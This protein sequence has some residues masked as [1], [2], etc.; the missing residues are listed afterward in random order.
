MAQFDIDEHAPLLDGGVPTRGIMENDTPLDLKDE[1]Q[2][3]SSKIR[4]K[5]GLVVICILMTELCE[6]LTYYSVVANLVL[7]CT[8]H[9]DLPSGDAATVS[10]VF[11]GTVYIIPVFGGYVSDSLAGKYNTIL[12]SAL[13]YLLGLFLL[14]AAAV[15]YT[16]WFGKDDE[17]TGYD[18]S[19][20]A[21]KAYFFLGLIFVAI[22]T[23]GI[24]ANV[25]PYG[26]QQVQA[27]GP[28]AVQ[29]FF[30][31]FYWFINAGSLV[32]YSG[33]AYIQQNISFGIGFLVPLISMIVSVIIFVSAKGMY[34]NTPIGG[35]ILTDSIGVCRATRCKGFKRA[36]KQ[37]GGAYSE[38]MVDGV[39][40]V[41]RVLP[42]FLLIIMYWAVYS[43]M[44]STFFLQSERMDVMV[45]D[46][47]MPAA[48][49]N[50]FNTVIILVLIPIIDRGIY[51]LL[52]KHGRSPS[53]LQRIGFGMV[54]AAMS[55]VVAGVLEIYR[56][57]NLAETGGIIQDLAG[58][59]FNASTLSV[60]LQVPEFALVG[61]SEVF[62]SIS[63]LEFAYSEAPDFM[64]G[65]VMGLFL[66]TSGLGSYVSTLILE[67]V[68]VSTTN[69]PWFPD[70]INEGKAEY[71][72]FLIG[73]LMMLNF[74]AFVIVA[75]LY[76]NRAS[77]KKKDELEKPEMYDKDPIINKDLQEESGYHDNPV[78][79]D[80]RM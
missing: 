66:M 51:P 58:D 7:F 41:L 40:C 38:E 57:E 56:K 5:T 11:S 80:T 39:I 6:R 26:A 42:V 79:T 76:K 22:G 73:G 78:G 60:F 29:S 59:T 1:E 32:A 23:G 77:L 34:I 33:V 18:L 74:F 75:K 52:A 12:G 53:H 37:N 63:G 44:Q 35:S 46:V 17:G 30:N 48:V 50:V 67:I 20:D 24:K 54:L 10:L 69:D 27:L 8:S 15:D 9:L 25:G 72:F 61:S 68:K 43:Q 64:Q 19:L 28:E 45:G 71:L 21:R 62:T 47:K 14:P 2:Q 31:W 65:L 36:R 70:E 4:G 49:L 3:K 13:I 16:E 55:V